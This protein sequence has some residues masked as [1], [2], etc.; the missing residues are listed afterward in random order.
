MKK[1]YF[2]YLYEILI[3]LIVAFLFYKNYTPGTFLT[4]WDNLQSE[5]YPSLSIKRAFFAVWQEYQSFGLVGGMAHASDIIR[6]LVIWLMTLILPLNIVR[7]AFSFLMLLIGGMGSLKAIEYLGLN[8]DKKKFA[9]I[10]SVFYMLNLGTVQMFGLPFEPF[11]IFFAAL[12]WELLIFFKLLNPK[13]KLSNKNL[14]IFLLINV[15]AT[16]QSYVQTLFII[17][18]LMLGLIFLSFLLKHKDFFTFKKGTI[19]LTLVICVNMFWILP[20][21]YFLKTSSYIVKESKTNQFASDDLYYVSKDKGIKE[22]LKFE[23]FYYDLYDSQ[24][25]PLF[26]DWKN[27]FSHPFFGILP[28]V[29]TG[30]AILGVF[31]INTFSLPILLLLGLILTSLLSS[32]PPFS[33]INLILR[34]NQFINIIFRDP[35]TKFIFP[36]TLIYSILFAWGAYNLS[37]KLKLSKTNIQTVCLMFLIL[38]VLYSFPA[39]KG[40]FISSEMK[41]KIPQEYLEMM[42]YFKYEDHNK[43]ITLLP[44]NTLWGWFSNKWGYDGSGFIW[45]G[46]EQPI[47]S[48]TFDV[49]SN[50]SEGYYWEM[51]TALDSVDNL[52]FK[53]VL[54]KYNIDFIVLDRSLLPLS[55]NYKAMQYEKIDEMLTKTPNLILTKNWKYLSIYRVVHN[56]PVD[57]F[58]SV[59]NNLPNIGPEIKISNDDTAYAN[60]GDYITDHTQKFDMYFPFLDLTTQA[61]I[62]NKKWNIIEEKKLLKFTSELKINPDSYLLVKSPS[63]NYFISNDTEISSISASLQTNINNKK[64]IATFP[65]Y[66]FFTPSEKNMNYEDCSIVKGNITVQ[67]KNKTIETKSINGGKACLGFNIPYLEQKYGYLVKINNKNNEGRRL[68]FYSV[69]GTKKQTYLED[70][71]LQDNEFYILAPK[72][73]YGLGYNFVFENQS[74]LHI[75]ASN[76]IK[77]ISVYFIPYEELKNLYFLNKK[78]TV[79]LTSGFVSNSIKNIDKS[80]FTYNIDLN[81]AQQNSTLILYQAHQEG[82]SAYE[83]N[84]ILGKTIPLVFGKKIKDHVLVNNWANGWTLRSDEIGATESQGELNQETINSSSN[85]TL[86]FW[87]QYLEFIGFALLIGSFV[88]ILRF[89]SNSKSE[90]NSK[91]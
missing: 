48:R 57:K 19:L 2:R 50:K 10:G 67:I 35:F 91:Q 54:E 70:R 68:Y 45:Y 9:F 56:K 65:K 15:L 37:H 86:I 51:R 42:D 18:V 5:L 84:N 22:F 74:Y 77:D 4:G 26:A 16:P 63:E 38:I 80:Y 52:K 28:Y 29:F 47:V 34:Q 23:G 14:F 24:I 59:Q 39:L 62:Q 6:T 89:K 87:P 90:S 25:T 21:A 69:D 44:D 13:I 73:Y 60:F 40:H 66:N 78:T 55:S 85:I 36:Y 32:V 3:T 12:P 31:Y 79:P 61:R 33:F 7:Y 1:F 76:T 8:G 46:I 49:W 82:W 71:L 58:V 64:I 30:I 83:T 43:R 53:Q 11:I 72:Y 27:H 88:Y 81:I 41:V 17:Y 20:Q 75:P